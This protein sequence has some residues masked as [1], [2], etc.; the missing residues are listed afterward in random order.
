MGDLSDF[1]RGQ[2]VAAHLAGISVTKTAT[3]LN[4]S[5]ATVSKVMLAYIN[6]RKTISAKRNSGQKSMLT[7]RDHRTLRKIISNNHSTTAAQVTGELNIHFEDPVSTKTVRCELQKSNIHSRAAVPK[8]LITES[9]A[10]TLKHESNA[11]T[12]KQWCHNHKTWTTNNWKPT[13]EMFR[14]VVLH[15]VPTSGR[16]YVWRSLQSG[17]PGSDNEKCGRICDGL[18]SNIVVLYW[19]HYYSSWLNYCK[20]ACGQFG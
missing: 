16:V 20:E 14:L 2:I 1:E 4:V 15:T 12:R 5:R 18:S 13:G 6:H 7:E 11:H 10:Q 9:N 17:M 8:P 19:S 3:L